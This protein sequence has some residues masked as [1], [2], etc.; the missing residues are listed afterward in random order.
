MFLRRVLILD[1]IAS[2]ATGLFMFAGAALLEQWLNLPAT[3]LRYAGLSLLPF[4]AIVAWLGLRREHRRAHR[5]DDADEEHRDERGHQRRRE[6]TE[7]EQN[8]HRRE[9]RAPIVAAG[10]AG[11]ER[12]ADAHRGGESRDE[13]PGERQRHA[14]AL[15]EL[16]Q[17]SGNDQRSRADDEVA[18]AKRG[19]AAARRI[20]HDRA[21]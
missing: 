11:E 9:Q 7:E 4:A 1:A 18:E 20:D 15:G 16:R 2:A 6:M 12:S 10:C 13:L 17:H 8:L 19:K 21:L 14:Q 3:L 5:S